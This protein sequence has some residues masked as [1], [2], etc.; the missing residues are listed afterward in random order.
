MCILGRG[1]CTEE[2]SCALHEDWQK[3][4]AELVSLLHRKT[5]WEVAESTSVR[6]SIDASET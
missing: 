4:R 1:Q 3:V 5:I 6:K 2:S